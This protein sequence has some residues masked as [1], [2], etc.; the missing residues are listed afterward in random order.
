MGALIENRNGQVAFS[1]KLRS[2]KFRR[3]LQEYVGDDD[4]MDAFVD[5]EECIE[6]IANNC[7]TPFDYCANDDECV[8]TVENAIDECP[9]CDVINQDGNAYFNEFATCVSN[10]GCLS[11]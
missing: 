2:L 7:E 1:K 11:A 5:V 8:D 6:C 4:E 9:D 10:N 3:R